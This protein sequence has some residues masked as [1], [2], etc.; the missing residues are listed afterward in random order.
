MS[1]TLIDSASYTPNSVPGILQTDLVEGQ[2]TGASHGGIGVDNAAAQALANRTAWLYA[3]KAAL[4]GN[5]NYQF[6]VAAA[7]QSSQAVNL[8]QFGVTTG[9]ASV[10]VSGVQYLPSGLIIQWGCNNI[11]APSSVTFPVTFPHG[12][13]QVLVCEEAAAGS[14]GSG[15]PT[16]HGASNPTVSGYQGWAESWTG[17]GWTGGS[18]TQS[19]LAIGW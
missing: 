3:N 1:G 16:V 15:T 8:G 11:G 9:P 2:A 4:T 17:S 14:W 13:F 18:I 5:A 6:A 10:G 19:F 12:C 7:T